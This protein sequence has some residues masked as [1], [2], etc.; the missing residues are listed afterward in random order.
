MAALMLKCVALALGGSYVESRYGPPTNAAGPLGLSTYAGLTPLIFTYM[1]WWSLSY[2]FLVVKK[3][4]LDAIKQA[5]KDGEQDVEARYNLPNLYA[6]GTS[7]AAATFNCVQRSHQHVLETF[8]QAVVTSLFASV[9][10]PLASAFN[11]VLYSVGRHAISN[12]YAASRGDATMRSASPYAILCWYGLF[13]N[14][15]LAGLSC[16][17]MVAG[18]TLLW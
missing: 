10:Y 16:A 5:K 11:A 18:K 14:V 12:G 7:K 15:L 1:C 9:Y 13:A 2:G 8:T 3:A 6:Q 17:N 4:R